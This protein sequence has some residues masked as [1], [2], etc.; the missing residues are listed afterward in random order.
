MK[1]PVY[2]QIDTDPYSFDESVRFIHAAGVGKFS[3][4][5]FRGRFCVDAMPNQALMLILAAN[6]AEVYLNGKT[7]AMFSMRSYM[8]DPVY[9]VYDITPYL[10]LGENVIAVYNIDTGEEIRAG[11]A[12][13]VLADGEVD[14]VGV[15]VT[16]A[17]A[18]QGCLVR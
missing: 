11:F 10:T 18:V 17:V 16:D 13:E 4:Q 8:F 7:V 15:D 3:H 2:A 6:A 9:E 12:L 5:M 1:N 14:A